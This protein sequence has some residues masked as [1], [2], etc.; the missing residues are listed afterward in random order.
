MPRKPL[1]ELKPEYRAKVLAFERKYRA[2]MG[3]PET[4]EVPRQLARGH[5]PKEH[6]TRRERAIARG[7]TPLSSA[8]YSF[9]RKQR[10]RSPRL[11]QRVVGT[12]DDGTPLFAN[13]NADQRWQRTRAA[14][15]RLSRDDRDT[16]RHRQQAME[17]GYRRAVRAHESGE[18]EDE[19]F[20]DYV[21][22]MDN[23]ITPIYF[24]H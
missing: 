17:R 1:D 23:D 8:D 4:A 14:Y 22:E 24:Y 9:L 16:V 11:T 6:I 2:A 20:Y 5:K 19:D 10:D 12:R 18:Y 7:E 13:E 3:L 21:G 15:L